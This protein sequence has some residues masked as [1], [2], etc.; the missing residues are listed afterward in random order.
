MKK[1]KGI[2]LSAFS[3][4]LG[5]LLATACGALLGWL[6]PG[7][8]APVALFGRM[9]LAVMEMAGTPLLM[10][11]TAFG[12]RQVIALPYP[13]RR[14][15]LVLALSTAALLASTTREIDSPKI[16]AASSTSR[17][18]VTLTRAPS[19]GRARHVGT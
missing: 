12:L 19:S 6:A 7:W 11:A 17:V 15:L 2:S 9:F 4:P 1:T 14:L 10:V 8:S 18:P 16:R 3:H 5:L 13:G